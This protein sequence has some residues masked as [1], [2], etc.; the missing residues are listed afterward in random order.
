M[1][2][3]LKQIGFEKIIILE[4]EK[5]LGGTWLKNNYPGCECDVESIFYSF[6]FNLNPFWSKYY[7]PS[8]EIKQ[9]IFDTCKKF[10][11]LEYFRYN[12]EVS[13][14]IW[15]INDNKWNI[16]LKDGNI[17]TSQFLISGT[18]QL[19]LPN[20]PEIK[21]KDNFKGESFHSSQW[22]WNISLRDKGIGVIGIYFLK[23]RICSKC[24]TVFTK[25]FKRG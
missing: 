12:C 17:L 7:S 19:N 18:G 22:N 25:N 21:G 13:T 8:S 11:I 4:K 16:V 5:E 20:I 3:K 10:Q 9:Y 23:F 1:A 24:C 6:S 14:A 15:D 2:I